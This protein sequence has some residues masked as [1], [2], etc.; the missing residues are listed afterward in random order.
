MTNPIFYTSTACTVHPLVDAN[1]RQGEIFCF[2]RCNVKEHADEYAVDTIG[3]YLLLRPNSVQQVTLRLP[4]GHLAAQVSA[5][6]CL[7][8]SPNQ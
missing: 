1:M 6:N 3:N 8:E 4:K 2:P 7:I 5:R